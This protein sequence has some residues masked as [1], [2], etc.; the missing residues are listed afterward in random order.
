MPPLEEI[1]KAKFEGSKPKGIFLTAPGAELLDQLE[2]KSKVDL[3]KVTKDELFE[4]LP[5]LI[6]SHLALANEIN[7]FQRDEEIRLTIRDS[8]YQNLYSLEHGLKS[9]SLLGCPLASAVA[10]ALAKSTGKRVFL[11]GVRASVETHSTM[12][13]FRVVQDVEVK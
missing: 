9:V 13:T 4:L 1:A 8:T 11:Q 12:I 7:L 10:C 6:I 5:D 3:T 2:K